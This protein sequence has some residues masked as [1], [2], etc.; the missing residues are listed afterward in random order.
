[1]K[2]DVIISIKGGQG[3]NP[4]TNEV[5]LVTEGKF[6]RQNGKAYICYDESEMT[7]LKDTHTVL[8]IDN[9]IVTILRTGLYPSQLIFEKGRRCHSLYHT[10]YGDL[11]VAVNTE[12]IRWQPRQV[13][14]TLDIC[15][16]LEI[17][18]AHASTSQLRIDV[19][20][21]QDRTMFTLKG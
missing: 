17:E 21:A 2:K 3:Q 18:H 8:T 11:T 5:A 19:T 7:G 14:G 12:S 20:S 1:M 4:D 15:Y 9:D 16:A 6:Y 13:G 10:D